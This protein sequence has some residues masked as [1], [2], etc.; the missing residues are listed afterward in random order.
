MLHEHCYQ[1]LIDFFKD[2]ASC[3]LC[4]KLI[5]KTKVEK[6]K[7]GTQ[8]LD[9]RAI[10]DPFMLEMADLSKQNAIDAQDMV[11]PSL[12]LRVEPEYVNAPQPEAIVHHDGAGNGELPQ[13]KSYGYFDPGVHAQE[14]VAPVQQE[15]PVQHA[16]HVQ[17]VEQHEPDAHESHRN[18]GNNLMH[19]IQ[20]ERPANNDNQ[21]IDAENEY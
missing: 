3:P 16:Q 10:N 7:L 20:A 15:Q 19:S 8:N 14:F 18:L 11:Y 6:K 5:E 4:R 12:S 9:N 17:H 2:D 21:S 13:Q 1:E